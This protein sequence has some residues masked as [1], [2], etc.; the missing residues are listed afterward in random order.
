MQ[1]SSLDIECYSCSCQVIEQLQCQ[2]SRHE[3]LS[4][5]LEVELRHH[6]HTQ[7][8]LLASL[9]QLEQW[10]TELEV[11]LLLSCTLIDLCVDESS[12]FCAGCVRL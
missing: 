9:S 4:M 12:R 2:H 1:C 5:L 10:K 11:L 6:R 3:L 7:R 8:L